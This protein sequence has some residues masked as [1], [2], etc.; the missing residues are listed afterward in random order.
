MPEFDTPAAAE[1]FMG[2][3]VMG[4]WNKLT[5][6]QERR[7]PFRLMRGTMAETREDLAR[8]VEMRWEELDGFTGGLF[9][10]E[11]S[12]E[13]PERAQRALNTLAEMRALLV[14]LQKPAQNRNQ[15]AAGE[16]IGALLKQVRELTRIAETEMQAAVLACARARRQ[17]LQGLP[18]PKP[19]RH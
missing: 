4:L 9:G 13:L 19:G 18:R 6:H 10:R 5:R 12:L 2:T 15:D 11:G 8:I 1:A 16:D 7:A 3:L 17:K 14:G